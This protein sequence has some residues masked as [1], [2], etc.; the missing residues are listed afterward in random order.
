MKICE[1]CEKIKK[2]LGLEKCPCCKNLKGADWAIII[3]LL[4]IIAVVIAVF[5]G[6]N[7]FISKSPV[8]EE[9]DVQFSVFFRHEITVFA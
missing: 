7:K 8:L 3:G 2:A 6:G 4:V 1:T 9:K 5:T